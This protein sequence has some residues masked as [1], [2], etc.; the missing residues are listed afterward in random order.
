MITTMHS[1]AVL[2]YCKQVWNVSVRLMKTT[3]GVSVLVTLCVPPMLNATEPTT[4]SFEPVAMSAVSRLLAQNEMTPA[5]EIKTPAVPV[6]SFDILEFRVQGV[7]LL[8]ADAIERAV[9]SYMGMHKTMQDV[10]QARQAV[11]QAYKN[12]G[13]PTGIVSIPE[14]KVDQGVVRLQVTEGKI[15]RIK[16][17]GS[18]YYSPRDIR[19]ALPSLAQGK[20]PYLPEIQIELE[21]LNT[22]TGDRSVVPVMKAGREPGTLDVELKVKDQ[23]PL[24]GKLEVSNRNAVATTSSRA[25]ASLNYDNLWQA[26][27]SLALQYQTSPQDTREVKFYVV[28]YSL[29]VSDD[30]ERLTMYAVRSDSNVVAG[31]DFSVVGN[32]HIYGIRSSMNLQRAAELFQTLSVG[33]DYKDFKE[34]LLQQGADTGKTPIS[35]V[36][37]SLR[38]DAAMRYEQSLLRFGLGATWTFRGLHSEQAQFD[39]KRIFSQSNFFYLSADANYQ[40]Q[41]TSGSRLSGRLAAQWTDQAL[42]S[43]EQFG[44]GGTQNVRGYYESQALGDRGYN[45]SLEWESRN[46]AKH[47]W[48]NESRWHV[49]YDYGSASINDPL[50]E[51]TVNF[52]LAGTGAGY[53][54]TAWHHLRGDIDVAYALRPLGVIHKGDVRY[55]ARLAYEF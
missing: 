19:H 26:G 55:H 41:Y 27:H 35:Y 32:G 44:I 25:M 54:F 47:S 37:F 5:A 8:P 39:D 33:M 22:T 17:S 21:R 18:Q 23:A 52:Y 31:Q 1:V 49:F 34:T 12:F 45:A 2:H 53:R 51:Q 30:N 43:N 16:V 10:E 3:Y 11:E 24:H 42:I 36:P 15:G 4:N 13:Y 29:P 38:Y 46:L 9:Y 28:S 40:Y 6:A 7:T 50:P 48:L 14:Q 20:V